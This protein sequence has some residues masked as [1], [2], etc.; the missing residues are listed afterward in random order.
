VYPENTTGQEQNIHTPIQVVLFA[1][2]GNEHYDGVKKLQHAEHSPQKRP[3]KQP[4]SAAA[5]TPRKRE[6]CKNPPKKQLFRKR[7]SK[8]HE[9][10]RNIEKQKRLSGLEYVNEAGKT[11][12][13]RKLKDMD[14]SKCKFKAHRVTQEDRQLI[15]RTYWNLSTYDKQRNFICQNVQDKAPT[16]I[17]SNRRRK[18]NAFHLPVNAERVRV[19]QKFF[20][21]A[22]D[23]GKKT[24]TFVMQNKQHGTFLG[25]DKRGVYTPNNKT[26][27]ETNI[28]YIHKHI[29]SFPTVSSHY[30]RKNTA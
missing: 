17:S 30:T 14:C 15:F 16:R 10:K 9:W 20:L 6:D 2:K 25:K 7:K 22:L 12:H 5:V 28:D 24:V 13:E 19:C 26:R 29:E 27:T 23:V 21:N 18:S 4:S 1:I 11:V 3:N 8:P